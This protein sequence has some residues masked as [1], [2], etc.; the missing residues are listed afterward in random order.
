MEW[1]SSVK[2]LSGGEPQGGGKQE[3][4]EG[5]LAVAARRCLPWVGCCVMLPPMHGAPQCSLIQL[6]GAV[7]VIPQPDMP[8]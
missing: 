5:A 3:V 6:A 2:D 1:A 8:W 4:E 7:Q